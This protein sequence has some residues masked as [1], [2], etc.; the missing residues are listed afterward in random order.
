MYWRKISTILLVAAALILAG[1]AQQPE[2]KKQEI[3][4]GVLVDLS[5]PLTTFGNNIKN[6][7]TV[8]E[9]EINKYFEEKGLPYTVKFYYEDTRVDPKVALEKVQALY[10]RGVKLI[11]GPMGSGEV[12]N[13]R[14]YVTSNKIIIIS[15]SSTVLPQLLGVTK[16]EEKKYIFRFVGTD[17][18]QTDA[19]VAELKDYGIKAVVITY[20]GN[21]WGKGLYETIKP[22][23]EANGIEIVSYVEYP[24]PPPADFQPYIAQIES[25]ISEA[26]Q[27]YN[28]SEVAVVA[29]SYEE[30]ATMLAQMSDDSV[31]LSVIWFGCDGTATSNKVIEEAC[32]KASK[33]KL[34]ST[35][36]ESYGAGLQNLIEKMKEKGYGEEPY[37]YALNAYD[38]AWVLALAYVET[39]DEAGKYD[40]DVMVEKIKEVAVKYS[41]GEYGVQPVSGYIELNE[42]N[43][44]ASGDYAIWYVTS[45]C[46]WEKAGVW[47]FAENKIE[48]T[49]KPQ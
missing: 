10:S 48:W 28:A 1:C 40:P 35:M 26:L 21:A 5:G 45:A 32:D 6:A 30:V 3:P 4:I 13:I 36:F 23:L 42:W 34:L 25:S 39:I 29:F 47:K 9:E 17:D 41:K 19:I 11:V 14:S 27:S 49:V 22:K 44:R 24:D 12:K 20:I 18:L 8:A 31:A 33:I 7:L 46:N 43:D 37:Q 16:P 2:V 38:A 15:P